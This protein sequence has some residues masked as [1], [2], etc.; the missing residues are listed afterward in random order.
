M[1]SGDAPGLNVGKIIKKLQKNY[2]FQAYRK[3]RNIPKIP[4]VFRIFYYYKFLFIHTQRLYASYK[5][6]LMK[7]I[8]IKH[9]E[10]LFHHSRPL[11]L[12]IKFEKIRIGGRW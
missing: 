5:L 8:Q 2:R 1:G 9:S 12:I 4:N 10:V 3:S 7:K 11:C 6:S